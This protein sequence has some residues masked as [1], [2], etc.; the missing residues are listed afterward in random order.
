MR[1]PAVNWCRSFSGAAYRGLMGEQEPLKVVE[2]ARQFGEQCIDI[3]QSLPRSAPTRLRG[4]LAEAGQAVG[5][6]L[7]EGIGRHTSAE[8][9]HYSR[10]ANGSLEETQNYL[11]RCIRR[12][13]IDKKTFFRTWNL[14]IV[15]SRMLA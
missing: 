12:E 6:I 11:R 5:D 14:S 3:A 13:L 1:S 2:A 9:I 7:V 4:Q 10:M 15:V 8:R